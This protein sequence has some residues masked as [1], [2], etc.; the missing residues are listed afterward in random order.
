MTKFSFID[1]EMKRRKKHHQLRQL[2]AIVPLSDAT[3]SVGVGG[4]EMVNFC[5]NDYM[6][7]SKD[8]RLQERA[9][10][11]ME[12][13]GTGSTA[14][15]LICGTYDCFVAVE[16]K[17]ARLKGVESALIL[18]SGFQANVSIIPILVDSESLIISDRLNHNSII[19]GIQLAGCQKTLYDHCNLEHLEQVLNEN[20]DRGYSR[21]LI[22]SESVFSVDGDRCDIDGLMDLAERHQAM[23]MVDEAHA[24]G[25]VGD[26]GMGLTA[27]K[28]VDVTIGTFGK[29]LGSF[30]AYIACSEQIKAYLINCCAG[31]IYTTAL[32]PPV[33]GA[34]D[35]ALDLIPKMEKERKALQD[36]AAFFRDALRELGYDTGNSTT[37]IVPVII[38]NEE[39]TLAL[40]E[41]LGHDGFLATAL[42]PPTVA[43]GQSRIRIALSAAHTREQIEQLID[44]FRKWKL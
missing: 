20:R 41:Q 17:L 2:R 22:I 35:A 16:E 30:G 29:A 11:F 42:R 27:G 32:P 44:V 8:P 7:L 5:S 4:G 40:S 10:D 23:L 37:Q 38:G 34:I 26:R 3:V 12:R 43:P 9:V 21:T 25:V 15:R 13:Y 28:N 24:T 31:F 14:S 1:A 6:G 33:I 36:N 18:N 39:E 19:Q